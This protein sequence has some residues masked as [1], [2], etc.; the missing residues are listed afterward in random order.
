MI[1]ILFER[2]KIPFKWTASFFYATLILIKLQQKNSYENLI[3][4]RVTDNDC[5]PFKYFMMFET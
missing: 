3:I 5:V 2:Q 4:R 1:K